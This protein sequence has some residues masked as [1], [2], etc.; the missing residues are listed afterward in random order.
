MRGAAVEAVAQAAVAAVEPA[1]EAVRVEPVAEAARAVAAIDAVHARVHG[2]LGESMGVFPAGTAYSARDP[3]LLRWVYATTADSFLHAYECFVGPLGSGGR[4]RYCAEVGRVDARLGVAAGDLAAGW[5]DL[6]A[7][8]AAMLAGGEIGVTAA[9]REVAWELLGS[10]VP[11]AMVPAQRLLLLTTL[12]LLPP[13]VRAGYGFAWGPWDEAAFAG[14][15]VLA[16]GLRP[17]LP[18]LPTALGYAQRIEAARRPARRV[19]GR[20]TAR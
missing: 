7:Y 20:S 8:L 15:A 2:R 11:R 19:R 10:P 6:Q 5:E 16:R 14:T 4:D 1:A 18:S 13:T 17:T 9:A 12:G 3:A